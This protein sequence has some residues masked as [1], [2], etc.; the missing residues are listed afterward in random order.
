MKKENF[1]PRLNEL[2]DWYAR[3]PLNARQME[4]W[5]EQ[6]KRVSF[7]PFEWSCQMWMNTQRNFPTPQELKDLL[8]DYWKTHPEKRAQI[9]ADRKACDECGGKGYF[10]IWYHGGLDASGHELYY[11]KA[12][13]CALCENWRRCG[14]FP[15]D[16]TKRWTKQ[17]IVDKGWVFENPV[18]DRF[19]QG[20][21][22]ADNLEDLAEKATRSFP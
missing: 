14:I 6:F 16:V 20:R 2:R 9:Q 3:K 12:L 8:V 18:W 15:P 1:L 11:N 21:V 17:Q 10:D 13:P 5:Y 4:M 19:D 7:E 22:E